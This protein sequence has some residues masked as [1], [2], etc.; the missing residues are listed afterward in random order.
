TT[1]K[2]GHSYLQ[3]L[4]LQKEKIKSRPDHASIFSDKQG[5]FFKL[6][7]KDKNK[8]PDTNVNKQPSLFSR[9]GKKTTGYM[10][11]LLH[12]GDEK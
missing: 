2:S 11:R 8:E 3:E 7:G 10:K 4:G 5:L 1:A 6:S 9:L 12:V